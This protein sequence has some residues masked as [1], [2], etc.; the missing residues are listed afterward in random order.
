[1]NKINQEVSDLMY[2]KFENVLPEF[3]H[4]NANEIRAFEF[5]HHLK[6]NN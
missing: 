3:E 1:M 5:F 4:L 6:K 2:T